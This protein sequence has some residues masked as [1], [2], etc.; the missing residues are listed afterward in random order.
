MRF[1]LVPALLALAGTINAAS[2]WGF[3]DAT[4][5][6]TSKGDGQDVTEKYV[7]M[8]NKHGFG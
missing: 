5:S 7:L 8:Q 2:Q 4:V 3:S 6:V 1:Q